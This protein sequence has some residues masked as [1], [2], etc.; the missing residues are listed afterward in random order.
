MT[1][2]STYQQHNCCIFLKLINDVHDM[3]GYTAACRCMTSLLF[4]WMLIN[5]FPR[6]PEFQDVFKLQLTV[7]F[8]LYNLHSQTSI[9]RLIDYPKF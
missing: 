4:S 5:S 8:I 2:I 1:T 6:H 3:Y 9:V 7:I